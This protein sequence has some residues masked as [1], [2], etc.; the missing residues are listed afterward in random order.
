M[1]DETLDRI[2]CWDNPDGSIR[3][4]HYVKKAM[5]KKSEPNPDTGEIFKEDETEDQFIERVNNKL[6][7]DRPEYKVLSFSL[8]HKKDLPDMFQ[9][10]KFRKMNG[11]IAID[12]LVK[13]PDELE[14]ERIETERIRIAQEK[15]R[16]KAEKDALKPKLLAVLSNFTVAEIDL[17]LE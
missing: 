9:K 14:R 16:I 13:T 4:T 6:K 15:A 3:M 10:R 8:H 12:P 1:D 2:T 17:M 5:R 7:R 11:K